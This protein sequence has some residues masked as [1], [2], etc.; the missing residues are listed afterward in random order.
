MVYSFLAGIAAAPHDTDGIRPYYIPNAAPERGSR[1]ATK[2]P[3]ICPSGHHRL[4]LDLDLEA[5]NGEGG[6][7]GKVK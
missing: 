4:G 3:N 6:D 2:R 1:L 7:A 5:G